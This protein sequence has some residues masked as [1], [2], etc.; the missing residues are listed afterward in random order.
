MPG[1]RSTNSVHEPDS[2]NRSRGSCRWQIAC[3]SDAH[4]VLSGG[5]RSEHAFYL[6]SFGRK[7]FSFQGAARREGLVRRGD[8]GFCRARELGGISIVAGGADR[9]RTDDL[10]LAKPALSQLSYSPV[11]GLGPR[12]PIRRVGRG[13]LELPTSRLSGVR[14]NHLSYRPG[15]VGAAFAPREDR[16]PM[17]S[18][19]PQN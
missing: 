13:R 6:A 1:A 2:T 18:S 10:R 8:R 16:K 11:A 5:E 12:R 14:S 3:F 15:N 17:A 4:S 19:V 9:D 7:N